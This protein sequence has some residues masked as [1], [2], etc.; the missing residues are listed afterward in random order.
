MDAKKLAE[1]RDRHRR[2]PVQSAY[3]DACEGE[4]W[5]CDA[6]RLAC[7]P[8]DGARAEAL[9]RPAGP[10]DEMGEWPEDPTPAELWGQGGTPAA[11]MKAAL[12]VPNVGDRIAV[13]LDVE[14]L[15]V[16]NHGH[17][18]EITVQAQWESATPT[19][20]GWPRPT[21]WGYNRPELRQTSVEVDE[22]LSPE[23]DLPGWR[24][25]RTIDV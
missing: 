3:C 20:P 12:R 10:Q 14:V 25:I 7:D 24:L 8:L 6:A 9:D 21:F 4:L 23:T 1:I 5:P 22:L 19:K 15:S 13:R 2:D 11:E 17:G 16:E 18:P